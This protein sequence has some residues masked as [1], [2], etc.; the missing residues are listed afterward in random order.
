MAF[1]AP[2]II[3]CET[4]GAQ[5][6]TTTS[7]DRRPSKIVV[8]HTADQN[9]DDFSLEHAYNLAR[10]IQKG[11]IDNGWGDSGQHFTIT[12]GGYI[13]EARHGSLDALLDGT[14]MISGAHVFGGPGPNKPLYNQAYIGIENEGTYSNVD[15]PDALWDSLVLLTSYICQQYGLSA[16]SVRGHR[17]YNATECPGTNLYRSLGALHVSIT[18]LLRGYAV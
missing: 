13:L 9:T 10:R 8:H 1:T 3:R 15:P 11:H 2:V 17:D 5:A 16:A 4:W 12:R 18:D 6:R 7:L 14:Y